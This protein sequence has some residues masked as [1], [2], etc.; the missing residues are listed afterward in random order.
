[1]NTSEVLAFLIQLLASYIFVSVATSNASKQTILDQ[2]T[3]LRS[4]KEDLMSEIKDTREAVLRESEVSTKATIDVLA[5]KIKAEVEQVMKA[6][7]Q[8][9]R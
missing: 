2:K 7:D 8:K 5:A 4:A 3:D 6:Q 9:D 1:M